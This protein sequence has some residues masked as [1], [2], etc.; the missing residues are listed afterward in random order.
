MHGEIREKSMNEKL[1]SIIIPVYNSKEYLQN[2]I[3]HIEDNSSI[4][5]EIIV[6]DDGSTDG[7]DVICENLAEK[8]HNII[9]I[10]QR[11]QGASAAR[12][13]GLKTASGKYVLFVDADDEIEFA[14][15]VEIAE[16]LKMDD[17]IDMAI[18]GISFDY[19]HSGKLYRRDELEPSLNGKIYSDEWMAQIAELYYGNS[20]SPIWNKVIKRSLL[21][22][23]QLELCKDMFLYEDLEFSLRCMAHCDTIYFSQEIIYHYRQSED[24]GNA[25]KR[26]KRIPHLP[27]LIDQI[28]NALDELIS[29]KREMEYE[30]QA[31]FIVLSLYLVIAREKIAVSNVEEI[32]KICDEF[33]EWIH[34]HNDIE[35]PAEQRK[36]VNLLKNR[37]IVRLIVKNVYVS[38]R[39]RVAVKVKNTWIYQRLKG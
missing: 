20:L 27:V 23:C 37:K 13:K 3:E 30:A 19:Y 4:D 7:T 1:L 33:S 24:E 12:N 22:D 28:E 14:K 39:H 25:G 10:H 8:Y 29:K 9:C 6:V 21:M 26:L 2:S 36:V 5:F 17:S 34:E 35:I 16:L 38:A 32:G 31:K 15:I 11:N 18:F